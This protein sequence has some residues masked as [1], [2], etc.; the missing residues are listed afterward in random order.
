MKINLREIE[1]TDL[2]KLNEWRN[3]PNLIATLG[4]AFTYISREVDKDWYCDYLKNRDKAVRLAIDVEGH[5]VGNVNLTNISFIHR[6]AEFSIF[7]GDPE[8]HGKGVGFLAASEIIDHAVRNLGLHR[9]WLTVLVDNQYAIRLYEKLGFEYEG[10]MRQS[11]YKQGKFHDM[12]IMSLI[13]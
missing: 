6:S 8:Y 4:T 3:D 13:L 9:I 7:I 2:E 5:Y 1:T 10:T 12:T 11:I